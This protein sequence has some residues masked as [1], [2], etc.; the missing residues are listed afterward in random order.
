MQLR[1]IVETTV[2]A[3]VADYGARF[4]RDART[5]RAKT[6]RNAAEGG[7]PLPYRFAL[8]ADLGEESV[9]DL[10]ELAQCTLRTRQLLKA[11]CEAWLKLP[12]QSPPGSRHASGEGVRQVLDSGASG[13]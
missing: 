2:K 10:R 1:L 11:L 3:L 6:G 4:E 5:A 7:V 13:T 8:P 12:A 9:R